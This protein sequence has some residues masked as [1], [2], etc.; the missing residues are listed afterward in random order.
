ME[1]NAEGIFWIQAPAHIG[2]TMFVRGLYGLG[3]NDAQRHQQRALLGE[4]MLVDVAPV[5]LKREYRFDMRQFASALENQVRSSLRL[6]TRLT[7][8]LPREGTPEQLQ[9][10]FVKFAHDAIEAVRTGPSTPAERLI[11][12]I[13]G[14]DELREPEGVLSALDYLPPAQAFPPGVTVLLTSRPSEDCPLWVQSR[15]GHGFAPGHTPYRVGLDDPDYLGLLRTY[16]GPHSGVSPGE[17]DFEEI[18]QILLERSQSLFPIVSFL[19][20]LV[21]D[22]AA[23][24]VDNQQR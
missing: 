24:E 3:L 9:A 23:S 22:G 2:K 4:N 12:A 7:L 20:D 16:V 8:Q 5:F 15:L 17:A 19:C 21:R 14:L 10:G 11:I 18:F 13:D 1:G 6:D